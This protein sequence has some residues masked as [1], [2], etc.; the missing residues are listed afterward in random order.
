MRESG[1]EVAEILI[2]KG[3]PPKLMGGVLGVIE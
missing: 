3:K 2:T 1:Y